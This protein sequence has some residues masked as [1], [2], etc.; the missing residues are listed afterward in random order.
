MNIKILAYN[1]GWVGGFFNLMALR[2]VGPSTV[3]QDQ[4]PRKNFLMS[5]PLFFW[6]PVII[7]WIFM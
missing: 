2:S 1:V 5:G 4:I 6:L 3:E 7:L